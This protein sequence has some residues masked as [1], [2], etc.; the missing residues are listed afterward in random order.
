MQETPHLAVLLD[1]VR[2]QRLQDVE[3]TESDA[4]GREEGDFEFG[5]DRHFYLDVEGVGRRILCL[6]RKGSD[7][8]T[9]PKGN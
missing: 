7:S 6:E 2:T 4:V 3:D 9:F 1:T 8:V 5:P